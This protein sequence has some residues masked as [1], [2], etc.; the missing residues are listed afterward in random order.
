MIVMNL[1]SGTG[2][3]CVD[4][5]DGRVTV[6]GEA[7]SLSMDPVDAERLAAILMHQILR[8]EGRIVE[9]Q[10]LEPEPEPEPVKPKPAEKPLDE[11]SGNDWALTWEMVGSAM[12]EAGSQKPFSGGV[13]VGQIRQ[14]LQIHPENDVMVNR[15]N[16]HMRRARGRGKLIGRRTK[17]IWKYRLR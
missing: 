12:I 7:G 4:Q 11:S 17:G 3:V 9:P 15:L 2:H 13:T 1:G 8:E 5:I 6:K 16:D 14:Q 10:E